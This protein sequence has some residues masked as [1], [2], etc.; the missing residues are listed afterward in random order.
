[1]LAVQALEQELAARPD[2]QEVRQRLALALAGLTV[3]ARSVT[4]DQRLVITS[5][6]QLELCEQAAHRIL[7]LQAGDERLTATAR[8]L[9]GEVAAGR[10]WVWHKQGP[11]AACLAFALLLGLAGAVAGGLTGSIPL[12]VAA[13]VVSSLLLV[14]VVLRFRRETWRVH[15]EGVRALIWRP[16]I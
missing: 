5:S 11:A 12:L 4:R 13:A 9:L 10:R 1:L 16:G 8:S 14:A 7:Q 2:D 15:A 6:R 3:A